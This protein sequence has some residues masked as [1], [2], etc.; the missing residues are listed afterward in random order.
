VGDAAQ[1]DDLIPYAQGADGLVVEATYLAAE[2]ELARQYG[3]L[4]VVQAAALARE[5]GVRTLF[6]NHIS[7]RYPAQEV[8]A[9]AES[10]FAS[11]IVARDFDRFQIRRSEQ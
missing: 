5:A 2:E 11:T 7:R 9:E 6:L 3:H 4:T 1:V 10:V 8:L